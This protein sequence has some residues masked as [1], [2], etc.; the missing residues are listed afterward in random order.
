MVKHIVIVNEHGEVQKK[1]LPMLSEARHFSED[2]LQKIIFDEPNLLS[3][4]EIDPDFS[5][6]IPINREVP[7]KSGSI[8][9][10]YIT[11]DGKICVVET[12]L[13]RNPPSSQKR[14]R[15]DH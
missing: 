7:V 15:S 4:E 14:G 6:L 8:D 11:P 9:A 1:Y 10:L 3:A 2:L 12:K 5:N 13:W